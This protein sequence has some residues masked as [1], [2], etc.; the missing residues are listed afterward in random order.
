[1]GDEQ[2]VVSCSLH[3]HQVRLSV[4]VGFCCKRREVFWWVCSWR[5]CWLRKPAVGGSPPRSSTSLATGSWQSLH[6]PACS[7]SCWAGLESNYRASGKAEDRVTLSPWVPYQ[8]GRCRVSRLYSWEGIP[9]ALSSWPLAWQLLTRWERSLYNEVL[10]SVPTW[11]LQILCPKDVTSSAVRPYLNFWETAKGIHRLF[12]FFS[13]Y[14][15][16]FVIATKI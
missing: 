12:I 2:P 6:Y 8:S 13:L 11:L 3:F 16:H 7:F 9:N 14:I 5:S 4:M 10:S 1:M 15:W